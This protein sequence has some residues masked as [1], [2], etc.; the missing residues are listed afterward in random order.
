MSE[1]TYPTEKFD[2]F[3]DTE[4]VASAYDATGLIPALPEDE[5]DIERQ[6][7]LYSIHKPSEGLEDDDLGQEE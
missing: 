3:W 4:Q 2:P 7:A 6:A 1:N 5:R